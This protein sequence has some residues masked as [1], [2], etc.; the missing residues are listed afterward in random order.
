MIVELFCSIKI[1]VD[2]QNLCLQGC[3]RHEAFHDTVLSKHM[4]R[5]CNTMAVY[6]QQRLWQQ[7]C[8]L[9]MQMLFVYVLAKLSAATWPSA[10]IE[11]LLLDIPGHQLYRASTCWMSYLHIESKHH[12]TGDLEAALK[13]PNPFHG[14]FN[15]LTIN[16]SALMGVL[17][18]MAV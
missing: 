7:S 15:D 12:S 10:D 9:S 16:D 2:C 3:R 18:C 1:C 5:H 17:T 8:L 6:V 13:Q 4:Q 14:T 11:F